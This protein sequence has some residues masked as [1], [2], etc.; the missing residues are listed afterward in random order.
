L[1]HDDDLPSEWWCVRYQPLNLPLE[2]S[3]A[4]FLTLPKLGTALGRGEFERKIKMQPLNEIQF[5]LDYRFLQT[6]KVVKSVFLAR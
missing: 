4:Y 1:R 2:I 3:P 6:S 5:A